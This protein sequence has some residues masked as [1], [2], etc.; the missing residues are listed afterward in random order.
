MTFF[1]FFF[2]PS[3]IAESLEKI[4]T[5]GD[6]KMVLATKR[7]LRVSFILSRNKF[8][9][10]DKNPFIQEPLLLKGYISN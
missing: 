4:S 3:S 7:L 2:P 5:N 9:K 8:A 6:S 10:S 1:L